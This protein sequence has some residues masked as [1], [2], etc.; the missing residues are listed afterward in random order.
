M[1]VRNN[2][3]DAMGQMVELVYL[4]F[5]DNCHM[6]NCLAYDLGRPV[7]RYHSQTEMEVEESARDEGIEGVCCHIG[8]ERCMMAIWCSVQLNQPG[9]D[10]LVEMTGERSRQNLGQMELVL[11]MVTDA[12]SYHHC[13]DLDAEADFSILVDRL[14]CCLAV[15]NRLFGEEID[16]NAEA[17]LGALSSAEESDDKEM[18]HEFVFEEGCFADHRMGILIVVEQETECAHRVLVNIF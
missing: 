18:C 13:M 7:A 10:E 17:S 16:R 11:G 3:C 14:W 15:E 9:R 12:S 8:V 5:A 1:G 2:H 6:E 4:H